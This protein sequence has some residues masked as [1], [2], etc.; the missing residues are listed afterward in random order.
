MTKLPWYS[1]LYRLFGAHTTFWLWL[2]ACLTLWWTTKPALIRMANRQ[3]RELKVVQVKEPPGMTRWVTLRGIEVEID[4]PLLQR[5]EE[6]TL[7]PMRF[8]LGSDDPAATWW[9]E[10]RA[11][12]DQARGEPTEESVVQARLKLIERRSLLKGEQ[13]RKVLPAPERCVLLQD[14]TQS[15]TYLPPRRAHGSRS[16][17][18]GGAIEDFE[19]NLTKWIDLVRARVRLDQTL[20]G[21]LDETPTTVVEQLKQELDVVPAPFV[22]QVDRTPREIERVVFSV[23]ALVLLF[24]AAGLYGASQGKGD[25]ESQPP[26][27][28]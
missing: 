3:P 19:K 24:L 4:R 12:C 7:P 17:H 15:V 10:T 6:A 8:L 27:T 11:L 21:V 28:P 22:L 2:V 20:E 16:S 26:S 13:R 5:E 9:A 1:F 18:G 25:G 23:S 14:L